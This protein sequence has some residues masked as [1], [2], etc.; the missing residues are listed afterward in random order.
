MVDDA[1]MRHPVT[2]YAEA[3][4]DEKIDAGRLVRLACQRH[5]DDLKDGADRGLYF[6]PDKASKPIRFARLLRHVK[7]PLA[8]SPL[9][10]AGWQA[11]SLGSAWGWTYAATGLRRFRRGYSQVAKKNGKT[12]LA[13]VPALL[14]LT[15]DGEGGPEIYSVAASR[16]QAGLL[17]KSAKA[18][19]RSSPLASLIKINKF[20]MVCDATAGEMRPLSRDANTADG[21]NPS[22]A[23]ADEIHRWASGEIGEII[24][25]S[26]IARAQ[27]L[28][29]QITTAGRSRASYCGEQRDYAEDV[30][31]GKVEDEE[32]FAYVSEPDRGE[33]GALALDDPRAW[34]QANPSLGIAFGEGAIEKKLRQALAIPSQMPAFKRLHLNTWTE[35]LDTWISDEV[36]MR[37]FVEFDF[38]KLRGRKAWGGLDLSATTDTTAFVIAVPIEGRVYLWR[39]SWIPGGNLLRNSQRDKVD[40][41]DWADRDLIFGTPGDSV[42]YGPVAELI[43]GLRDKLEFVSIAFD[44]AL[45][46]ALLELEGVDK[47]PLVEHRQGFLSMSPAMKAF[48]MAA[49]KGQLAHNGDPVLRWMIGNVAPE[50]DAVENIKPSKKKSTGRIDAA[51]AAIMAA[52]LAIGGDRR[53]VSHWEERARAA[54][55][56][57]GQA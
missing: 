48:E 55:E 16:D 2:Q 54:A 25:D 10:L 4:L 26:M 5:L 27:P 23:I 41:Q 11:F 15:F 22:I 31:T 17:F 24:K 57:A 39:W 47:L 9:E 20:D 13:A 45:S 3:V 52:G 42:E 43:L 7:G 14:G 33:D 18:M 46:R 29:W 38:E 49:Y 35:S 1:A 56:R 36:W 51:V 32:F 44:P 50:T 53:K 21:V 8:G 12:T 37:N 19:V 28:Y 34:R 40:Y 30:L 6:D